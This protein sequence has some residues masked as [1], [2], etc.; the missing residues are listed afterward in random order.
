MSEYKYKI[1]K[2]DFDLF[3]R[4]D[5]PDHYRGCGMVM[6]IKGWYVRCDMQIG[7]FSAPCSIDNEGNILHNTDNG[8]SVF[9]FDTEGKAEMAILRHKKKVDNCRYKF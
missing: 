1:I 3:D 4:P 9:I 6:S 8:K 5:L 2:I 7:Q